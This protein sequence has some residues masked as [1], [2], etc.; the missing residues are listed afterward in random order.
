MSQPQR[1]SL[2]GGGLSVGDALGELDGSIVGRAEGATVGFFVGDGSE[3]GILG[4]G[5]LR[6]NSPQPQAS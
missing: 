6:L 4:G 3:T 1:F 2:R 5:V